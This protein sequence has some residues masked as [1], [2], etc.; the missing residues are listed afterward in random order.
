[1]N[2][3]TVF[4]PTAAAE[5]SIKAHTAN[6]TTYLLIAAVVVLAGAIAVF[7]FI[8]E[9]IERLPEY[10]L[11]LQL[12]KVRTYRRAVQ[13]AIKAEQSRLTYAP[14]LTAAMDRIFCLG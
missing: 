9:H 10:R 8:A 1:M 12:A 4:A 3:N 11:H 6:F 14:K 2:Y 5:R 7:D 13:W